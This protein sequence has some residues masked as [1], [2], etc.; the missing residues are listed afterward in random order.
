MGT[1]KNAFEIRIRRT[2]R[3]QELREVH[4]SIDAFS[5]KIRIV[6]GQSVLTLAEH[7]WERRREDGKEAEDKRHDM[8]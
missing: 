7:E 4:T 8:S 2:H 1:M 6:N 5:A 3:R